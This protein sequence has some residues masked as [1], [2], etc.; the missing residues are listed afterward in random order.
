VGQYSTGA[1]PAAY[2]IGGDGKIVWSG[3]PGALKDDLVETQLKELD[4]EHQVSTWSFMI[5][6]SLPV[7]PAKLAGITKLLEKKKFGGALK[8]V[9]SA[10]PKLEGGDQ[11]AG[12]QI[13]AWIEG[14]GTKGIEDGAAFVADGKIYKGFLEYEKV[15]DWFKGH[16]LAK[17]A[18]TAAKALTSD[19]ANGLEIKASEKLVKIKKEMAGE[20]KAEDQLK[21]LKPLLAK[22]Y[23]ETLAGKEA[24]ELAAGLESKID[25]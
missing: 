22:K 2:L 15:E 4:D 21:C 13:R 19:K 10:L 3:N 9:E 8:K 6:K 1:V 12:E 11:E 23:A 25:K 16:D 18:K 17:Q 24:A 14:V 5:A 20:R 7:I